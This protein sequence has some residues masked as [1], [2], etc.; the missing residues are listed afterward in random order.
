[1][2]NVTRM[3]KAEARQ[4]I[5]PFDEGA[6]SSDL[7]RVCRAAPIEIDGYGS[8]GWARVRLSLPQT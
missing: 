1:V 3:W 2:A 6:L 5:R 4:A 7:V 8:D